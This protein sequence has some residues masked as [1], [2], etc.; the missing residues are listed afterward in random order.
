MRVSSYTFYVYILTLFSCG[1]YNAYFFFLQGWC[2]SCLKKKYH[3]DGLCVNSLSLYISLHRQRRLSKIRKRDKINI[4]VIDGFYYTIAAT[5]VRSTTCRVAT[6]LPS[7]SRLEKFFCIYFSK[8]QLVYV[9]SFVCCLGYIAKTTKGSL[10][11]QM[12]VYLNKQLFVY[13]N[14]QLFV[15]LNKQLFVYLNKDRPTWCHLLFYFI[16]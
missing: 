9:N 10:R 14:K 1:L 5:P 7:I 3:S 16:I 6:I 8:T 2:P 15:Y 12:L 11:K 4:A 13:L